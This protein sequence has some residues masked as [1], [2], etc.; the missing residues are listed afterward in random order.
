M[1]NFRQLYTALFLLCLFSNAFAQRCPDAGLVY[2]DQNYASTYSGMGPTCYCSVT[3]LLPRDEDYLDDGSNPPPYLGSLVRRHTISN[4]TDAP[5][6]AKTANYINAT[7]AANLRCPTENEYQV[8]KQIYL[9]E[10]EAFKKIKLKEISDEQ[11]EAMEKENLR[12]QELEAKKIQMQK[13]CRAVPKIYQDVI[14]KISYEMRTDPQS[15]R[16]NRVS[17]TNDG[18][19]IATFYTSKGVAK[20]YASFDKNGAIWRI[21]VLTYNK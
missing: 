7:V 6:W 16:L 10:K 3:F 1:K 5:R 12:K 13:F 15:I 20:G 4:R 18:N 2:S 19:C 9:E 14:E 21:S 11:T 8:L 17:D